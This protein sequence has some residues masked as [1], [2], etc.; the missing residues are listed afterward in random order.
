MNEPLPMCVC[1]FVDSGFIRGSGVLFT[2]SPEKRRIVYY[3]SETR[4]DVTLPGLVRSPSLPL[5]RP[6]PLES[7]VTATAVANAV[8]VVCHRQA[9]SEG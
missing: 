1:V 7:T 2:P 4:E 9:L 5:S 6:S 3:W 8:V